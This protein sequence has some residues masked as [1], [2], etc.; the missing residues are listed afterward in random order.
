MNN[1]F[2]VTESVIF[3]PKVSRELKVKRGYVTII[4]P[5]CNEP[6]EV[7]C[8]QGED[9]SFDC[10]C[11]SCDRCNQVKI[12][13]HPTITLLREGAHPLTTAMEETWK[14]SKL[15]DENTNPEDSA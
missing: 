14:E 7:S 4:C 15:D 6:R 10:R 11:H 13:W 8:L 5:G 3:V 9:F 1:D 12:E 2:T